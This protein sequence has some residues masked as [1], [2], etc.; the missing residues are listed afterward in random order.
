[1]NVSLLIDGLLISMR[2]EIKLANSQ[3]PKQKPSHVAATAWFLERSTGLMLSS[4][5]KWGGLQNLGVTMVTANNPPAPTQKEKEESYCQFLRGQ[6]GV[7]PWLQEQTHL[8]HAK[9][10]TDIRH[11]D[12]K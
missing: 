4:A 10:S 3:R 12:Y 1:M 5:E 6:E 8:C 9:Y 2:R 7:K 11:H